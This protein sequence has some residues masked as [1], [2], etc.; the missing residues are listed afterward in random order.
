[1]A[2]NDDLTGRGLIKTKYNKPGISHNLIPRQRINIKLDHALEH[3]LTLVTAPAGSGKTTAVLEWLENRGLQSAWLSLDESEND[4]VRFWQYIMAAFE[5]GGFVQQSNA[6]ADIHLSKEHILSNMFT[7]LFLEKLRCI[8]G[9]LIIIL[10]DFHLIQ[11]EVVRKSLEYFIK[12]A[13][14][15]IHVILLSREE[16]NSALVLLPARDQV[17]R[18]GSSELS[19]NTDEITDFFRKRG[20]QLASE[21]ISCLEASTEGW[22]SGLVTVALTMED[23]FD[24]H[25]AVRGFSGSNRYISSFIRN[26]V[27]DRRPEAVKRF[28]V[29][30]SF[31]DKLSQPL[32]DKVT[33]NANSAE[34]LKMLSRTNSFIIPLDQENCWFRYHHLFQEFLLD[35]LASESATTRHALYDQAGQWYLEKGYI[36]D[37]IDCFIKA[38]EF[39][40]AFPLVWDIY[41]PMTQNGEYSTWRKWMDRMPE[42]LCESDVRA[43]TGYSWV[44]SMENRLD[45]A[46]LWADKA[47]ACYDRMKDSLTNEEKVYLEA[48][49]ALTYANAALFR[50]DVT[51]AVGYFKKV[52]EFN[53]HTPIFIGEMNSGEPSLLD[54][55]L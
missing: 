1:M 2:K 13:P 38:K 34:L 27:F 32:C 23:G 55:G 7:D 28:L 35:R 24:I 41:L 40:K 53:L 50:M 33:G 31:L 8:A 42:A 3:K 47:R 29:H 19:F 48:H 17:L 10:D 26:E 6:F 4:L 25:A 21:D 12:N 9:N 18:L 11:D 16:I 14:P 49:I 5:A 39:A 36:R 54:F 43:C 44:L 37:A 52:C 20:F 46:E 15:N 45:E 51:G 22:V 30:T